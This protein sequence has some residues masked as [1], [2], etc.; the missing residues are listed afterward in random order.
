M[1][2]IPE[3]AA[4]LKQGVLAQL[5]LSTLCVAGKLADAVDA[6]RGITAIGAKDLVTEAAVLGR[7][8]TAEHVVG[9]R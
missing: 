5:S 7:R 6:V 8:L 3:Q 1:R 9:R 2:R 4:A